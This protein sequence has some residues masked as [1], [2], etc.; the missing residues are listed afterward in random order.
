MKLLCLK[1]PFGTV[2]FLSSPF[3]KNFCNF[4]TNALKAVSAPKPAQTYSDANF[5]IAFRAFLP[6]LLFDFQRER[7]KLNIYTRETEFT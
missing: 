2:L 5:T 1:F 6:L 7:E 3:A 4:I